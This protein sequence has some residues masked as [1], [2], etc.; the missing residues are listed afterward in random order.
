MAWITVQVA[1]N[2]NDSRF[3]RMAFGGMTVF[4][5]IGAGPEVGNSA[6]AIFRHEV[7]PGPLHRVGI[8]TLD[9]PAGG[10]AVAF[11]IRGGLQA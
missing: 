1:Q 10:G 6:V 4:D 9:S 8:Q 7:S 2:G 11:R 3:Y 5:S